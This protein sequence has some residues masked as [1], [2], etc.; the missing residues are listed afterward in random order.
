M[1]TGE[2]LNVLG[3]DVT[4]LAAGAE[5]GGTM[6]AVE[7]LVRPGSGPPP[8]THVAS[9]LLYV[10]D[11]ELEVE[12]DGGRQTVD[13]GQ[14]AAVPGGAV[15]TYRNASIA[16]ARCCTPRARGASSPSRHA[17]RRTAARRSA[18]RGARDAHRAAA[19]HRVR[20]GGAG[21][22]AAPPRLSADGREDRAQ[23]GGERIRIAL[24]AELA[25]KEPGVVAREHHRLGPEPLRH[26]QRGAAGERTL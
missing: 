16:P 10:L 2:T 9:E 12:L 19:R 25:A 4:L 3:E 26:G 24:L 20:G 17:D 22:V 11:G 14:V 23:G 18:G 21:R 13:A 8:H 6:T 7:V 15:H 5:T 1:Q